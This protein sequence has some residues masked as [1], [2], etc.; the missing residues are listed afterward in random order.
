MKNMLLRKTGFYI[1]RTILYIFL[2]LLL[3]IF[4]FPFYDVFILAT[5]D[6]KTIFSIPPPF[7]PGD[8]LLVNWGILF[9]QIPFAL[10]FFHS[11]IIAVLQTSTVIF[12]CTMGGFALAKYNFK[13]KS[14]FFSFILLTLMIP[15]L[16]GIIPA[17]RLML[18][19]GWLNTYWPMFIPG[20]A[21]AFGIFLMTQF[22]TTTVPSDLMDAARIDGLNEFWILLKIGF[23]L[24]MPGIAV[25]GT[26]T[27]VGSWN[28]FLWALLML[29]KEEM[30][31]IPP[32]LS[33]FQ[34]KAEIAGQGYG[35]K[36]LGNALAIIPLLLVFILFS[37][38]IISNFLAGSLKG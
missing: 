2:T 38:K 15:P 9:E 34:L 26:I 25:L 1:R 19:F 8:K 24:S 32:A 37:K 3:V 17:Y 16:L 31:T 6:L 14:F 30:R 20:M 29:T 4:A 12:F 33:A 28:N 35:A 18:W 5:R 27:F 13:G 11:V 22:I 7:T 36:M 21:N 10:N 23:P